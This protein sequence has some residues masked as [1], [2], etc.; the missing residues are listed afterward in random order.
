MAR[1]PVWLEIQE[2]LVG[3]FLSFVDVDIQKVYGVVREIQIWF[4]SFGSWHRGVGGSKWYN[5]SWHI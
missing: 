3:E 1:L 5:F 2:A 4:G